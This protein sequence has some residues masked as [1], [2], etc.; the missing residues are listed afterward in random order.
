MLKSFR[1]DCPIQNTPI[2][3]TSTFHS[4]VIKFVLFISWCWKR[5]RS[6]SLMI[7]AWKL[8][9]LLNF[10]LAISLKNFLDP[11]FQFLSYLLFSDLL[12][13]VEYPSCA[14]VSHGSSGLELVLMGYQLLDIY[15][16][17]ADEWRPGP[18]SSL[19]NSSISYGLSNERMV[20][21]FF[22]LINRITDLL[23]L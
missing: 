2:E 6:M 20:L 14:V 23:N 4:P 9:L 10:E 13:P 19:V 21:I 12:N 8:C 7:I 3:N 22:C 15:N 11:G 16:F 1:F 17:V 5:N 18:T